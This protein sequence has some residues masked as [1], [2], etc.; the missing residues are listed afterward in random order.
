MTALLATP[1]SDLRV[2]GRNIPTKTLHVG[3]IAVPILIQ[4]YFNSSLT[5]SLMRYF[6]VEYAV[7]APAL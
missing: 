4:V 3:L 6:K 5:Y 2:S 7:A 1:R